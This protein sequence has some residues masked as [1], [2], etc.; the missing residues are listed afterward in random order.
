LEDHG[1]KNKLSKQE[2]EDA[3][4]NG[5]DA[6]HQAV[7]A[8]MYYVTLNREIRVANMVGDSDN[9]AS[10]CHTALSGDDMWSSDTS[11]PLDDLLAALDVPLMRPNLMTIS[12]PGW[13]RVRSHP[14][15]I[16][17]IKPTGSDGAV[18]KQQVIEYLEIDELLVGASRVNS[19]RK[20]QAVSLASCWG[21]FCALHFRS[22]AAN[23]KS[24]ITWGMT[25]PKGTRIAG[26]W[27]EK[28]IGLEG[29]VVTV[30][31]EILR[32]IVCAPSAGYL[33]ENVI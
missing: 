17:A 18:T 9:Y 29:G 16:K 6:V 2:I 3:K 28:E 26:S 11:K 30:A 32:E 23:T 27:P 21:D 24:G 20:G 33:F 15:V 13:T 7:E 5:V 10:G 31:G 25:V 19:A 12:L 1:L 14:N 4:Q 22:K 8:I